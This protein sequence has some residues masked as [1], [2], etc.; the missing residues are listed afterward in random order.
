MDCAFTAHHAAAHVA[1]VGTAC[2][3]A[4]QAK[5]CSDCRIVKF[6]VNRPIPGDERYRKKSKIA[7]KS[8]VAGGDCMNRREF[9]TGAAAGLSAAYLKP[10]GFGASLDIPALT[11]KYKATDTVVPGKTGIRTRR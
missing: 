4:L 5:A 1:M 11:Q 3:I 2:S 8:G 6:W 9:L 10:A 7:G